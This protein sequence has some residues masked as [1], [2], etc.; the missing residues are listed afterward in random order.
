MKTATEDDFDE[1]EI[2][3]KLFPLPFEWPPIPENVLE[4]LSDVMKVPIDA[5]PGYEEEIAKEVCY[6]IWLV[7]HDEKIKMPHSPGSE[8]VS[9]ALIEE[10]KDLFRVIEPLREYIQGMSS[11]AKKWLSIFSL[12]EKRFGFSEDHHK[13]Q[14]IRA[15]E[16]S[17]RFDAVEAGELLN[18]HTN[19]IAALYS[20][21]AYV[22]I[23]FP[24]KPR[25]RPAKR[26]TSFDL[27]YM[28][29]LASTIKYGG[30]AT[31]VPKHRT[32][33]ILEFMHIVAPHVPP[34]VMP[35]LDELPLNRMEGIKIAL[36]K[37][38]RSEDIWWFSKK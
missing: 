6:S 29:I 27:F 26:D 25:Q 30:T 20:A 37:R 13:R 34:D 15:T 12:A 22:S 32:G 36:N 16:H 10:L 8:P 28:G 38:L 14:A 17:F 2:Y 3:R 9:P 19:A 18:Q 35:P 33:T 5:R 24:A 11:D 23:A 4:K 7:G 31:L 21:S 1:K